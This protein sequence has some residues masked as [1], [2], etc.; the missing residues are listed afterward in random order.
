MNEKQLDEVKIGRRRFLQLG[1][2]LTFYISTGL[3]LSGCSWWESEKGP[4]VTINPWVKIL[5]DDTVIICNPAAEMGQ[6]SSTAL[7]LILAEEMDADWSKVKIIDSPIDPTI[8]GHDGWGSRPMM[9]IVGSY[10]VEGYYK[11]LR[12]AG[13]Q[14]KQILSIMAANYWNVALSDVE[15][16]SGLVRHLAAAKEMS[17]GEIASLGKIPESLPEVKPDQLK[18]ASQFKIIGT[19]V[20]RHDIPPKVNGSAV[21]SIDAAVPNMAYGVMEKSPTPGA[22]PLNWNEAEIKSI[23]G[24][25][26]VVKFNNAIGIIAKSS[27]VALRAKRLLKVEWKNAPDFVDYNSESDPAEYKKLLNSR[28]ATVTQ[29]FKWGNPERRWKGTKKFIREYYNDYTYHSQLEPVNAVV[30]Y[31][32]ESQSAEIWIGTQAPDSV[33]RDAARELEL[34]EE[35][36]VIHRCFL[37]GGFG[38]RTRRDYLIDACQLAKAS[39]LPVKLLWTREDDMRHGMFRPNSLQRLEADVDA[40]GNI[41]VWKYKVA[42]PGKVLLHTGAEIPFYRIPHQL[43]EAV[44]TERPVKTCSWRAEGHGHNK[45]AIEA[46]VD[47]IATD[48]NEDTIEFHKRMME[49]NTQAVAV[50]DKVAQMAGWG[51]IPGEGRAFGFSFCERSA[52]TATVFEISLDANTGKIEIHRVWIA[53]D[54]GIVVQP[55]NA[56]MQ[57]EGAVIMGISSSLTERITFAN[58]KVDQENFHNYEIL[59]CASA[60]ETI[61]VAF[62]ESDRPPV[63]IGEAG[64][65]GIGGA[66]ANAFAA[67]TGQRLY[68]MPFTPE[69]V[70]EALS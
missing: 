48:L 45:Y 69:R 4:P 21:Y 37:G 22:I 12:L 44:Y 30:S 5:P 39:R 47:E 58:G 14:V 65:P 52:I 15:T 68:Q 33:L 62:I 46:F 29:I 13:A 64:I 40:T 43:H 18:R 20:A 26:D 34:K 42:G 9:A 6:G 28:S 50:V 63:G 38:R 23:S 1:G 10:A 24:V 67:L 54:A 61:E 17:F 41:Q 11:N 35:N 55:D 32:S 25:M 27:A 36:I 51:R 70:K 31:S 3:G 57:V 7:P 49:G 53:L 56:T 59:R 19:S 60:P 2:G 8:F 66:I 16:S